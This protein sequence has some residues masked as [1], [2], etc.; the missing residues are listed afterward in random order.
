MT[1]TKVLKANCYNAVPV[2]FRGMQAQMPS[3][4]LGIKIIIFSEH[5][6]TL[7]LKLFKIVF[8]CRLTRKNMKQ[9]EL[10]SFVQDN[11]INK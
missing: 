4:F 1:N 5:H 3:A 9:I 7:L 8:F 11:H 2:A 6:N 10:I